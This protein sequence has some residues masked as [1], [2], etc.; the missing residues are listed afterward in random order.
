MKKMLPITILYILLWTTVKSQNNLD[1][2]KQHTEDFVYVYYEEMTPEEHQNHTKDFTKNSIRLTGKSSS[3]T[4][5]W[6]DLTDIFRIQYPRPSNFGKTTM[7]AIALKSVAGQQFVLVPKIG[8]DFTGLL[9]SLRTVAANSGAALS[10]LDWHTLKPSLT[11]VSDNNPK[12]TKLNKLLKKTVGQN[13]EYELDVYGESFTQILKNELYW[14]KQ[15]RI[16]MRSDTS[17]FEGTES[18]TPELFTASK[19]PWYALHSINVNEVPANEDLKLLQIHFSE[20]IQ[21]YR[22]TVKI[23]SLMDEAKEEY[24]DDDFIEEDLLTTAI[25]LYIMAE[26][27]DEIKQLITALSQM[28]KTTYE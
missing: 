10:G 25:D 16:H 23:S 22:Y 7:P 21:N 9:N 20:L 2:L 1:Y 13:I 12:I 11:E 17:H 18:S 5:D 4:A 26:D 28:D 27:T 15:E 14:Q 8:T 3:M 19:I 24:S 6:K